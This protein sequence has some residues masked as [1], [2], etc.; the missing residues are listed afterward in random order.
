MTTI[1]FIYQNH[2]GETGPRTIDVDRVEFIREPGFGYH[3]GWFISGICHDRQ[4]RRSFALDRI[5]M[6]PENIPKFYTLLDLSKEP[7]SVAELQRAWQAK[8]PNGRTQ[9]E[10]AAEMEA[11]FTKL[12][13]SGIKPS[14]SGDELIELMRGDD[15]EKLHPLEVYRQALHKIDPAREGD[16]IYIQKARDEYTDDELEIDDNPVVSHGDDGVW[17]SAWVWVSDEDVE[18]CTECGAIPGTPTYGTVGDGYDGLC[19]SCADKAEDG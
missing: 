2:R 15:D 8:Y 6:D 10:V 7:K 19:P 11:G 12:Q 17:V 5:V 16:E 13:E 9:E 1:T 14:M 4:A 18:A 3:A